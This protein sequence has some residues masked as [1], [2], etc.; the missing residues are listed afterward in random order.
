MSLSPSRCPPASSPWKKPYSRVYMP[1]ETHGKTGFQLAIIGLEHGDV[2]TLKACRSYET[3][4][5]HITE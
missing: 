5:G 4:R 1:R 3:Y 2:D